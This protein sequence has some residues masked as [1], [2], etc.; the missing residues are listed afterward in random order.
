MKTI[1][2]IVPCFNEEAVLN[3]FY[4]ELIKHLKLLN[5]YRYEVIFIN[6]GSQDNT[7]NIINLLCHNDNHCFYY[8]LSRNF[9][10]EAAIY[11]GLQKSSGDYVV[12]MDADLQDPPSLLKTMVHYL[13][14]GYD[15]V[16][17]RRVSRYGEPP[18]RSLCA[19][20]FYRLMNCISDT[21]IKDG[22]RDY[23][24]MNRQF[25][26]SL[27][28][29]KEYNRFSKG[30]FGWVGYSTKWLEFE[31]VERVAGETKWSFL[32]LLIYSIQ[33]I[34]AFSTMPL[35]ISTI[36]GII[37]CLL[38]FIFVILIIIRT[39][40][41]GDPVTGWPSLVC[42]ILFVGGIQLFCIGVLGQYLAKT[43]LEVK[44]RPLYIVSKTNKED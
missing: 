10:K 6:D 39:L 38:A 37:F 22:A 29:L 34:V 4:Q 3:I 18:I 1:S 30:L 36:M 27:L 32:K 43:Y 25:V 41:F 19:R 16:A 11:L 9:G 13:E 44:K 8:Q 33:G 31:N 28:E 42:I 24:M 40:I 14:N 2:V 23:R 15:S 5:Q 21:E 17:S 12:I 20:L 7:Q 26:N 35:V